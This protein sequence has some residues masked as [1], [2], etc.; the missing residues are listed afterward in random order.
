MNF[1]SERINQIIMNININLLIFFK[2]PSEVSPI[3]ATIHSDSNSSEEDPCFE[4]SSEIDS[5]DKYGSFL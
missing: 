3:N 2:P 1:V 5:L 4:F